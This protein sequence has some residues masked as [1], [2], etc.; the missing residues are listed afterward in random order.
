MDC[1]VVIVGAGPA[2]LAAA[3]RLRQLA[4]ETG[5]EIGVTVLEKG[6]EV[7]AHILSG[8]VFDP[9]ALNAL[10]PDWREKEAP[11]ATP[12]RTDEF[13]FL[14]AR[15]GFTLPGFLLPPP[16]RNHGNYVISLGAL[17]RWLGRQAEALGA[18]IY[19]GFAAADVLHADDGRVA[20]VATGDMGIA[21]DGTRKPGYAPG[22][23]LRAKYTLF[24]EGARGSLTERL[25]ERFR[26]RAR[27]A[28]QTYG[29]GLKELWEIEPMMLY[30][31]FN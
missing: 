12:A 2:G 8:A 23:D 28:P 7:G 22:M 9:R 5:R 13:R 30:V 27:A 10:I 18:E 20:G 1:D 24:A 3:I 15:G 16:M 29:I 25:V 19:P 14:T 26:L 17:C 31:N 6:A 21:R 11:L 4:L